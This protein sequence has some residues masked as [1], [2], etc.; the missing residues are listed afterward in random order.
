LSRHFA[1]SA[2]RSQDH[3]GRF[4]N[5]FLNKLKIETLTLESLDKRQYTNNSID[6]G[7][8]DT[9]DFKNDVLLRLNETVEG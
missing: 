5:H 1:I 2:V 8:K 7:I 9:D 3:H 6:S 4:L